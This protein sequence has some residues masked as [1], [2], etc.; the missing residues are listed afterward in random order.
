M[1]KEL[2]DLIVESRK[3]LDYFWKEVEGLARE[4][5]LFDTVADEPL[6]D[7]IQR[8]I[9]SN[10]KTY[11]Y[12]LPAQ[13]VAKLT[14]GS[15]DCRCLQVLR[16]GSGAFDARSVC[17]S[18]I[19][20]FDQQNDF[21]LGGSPEP[22]VNNP[23]RQP[24]VTPQYRHKQK[25]KRGWDDLCLV[26]ESVEDKNDPAF[27]QIVFKQTLIEI[28]KRLAGVRVVY[29]VPRRVSFRQGLRLIERFITG[30][31]GGERVQ[32]VASALFLTIG[33]RFSLYADVRRANINAADASSGQVADLEC[34]SS[35]GEI[36]LAVEVKDRDL[37]V[38]QIQD[39][40]AGMRAQ[41][42]TE[43]LFIAQQG[44]AKGDEEQA[45]ALIEKEFVSGQNIYIFDLLKLLS[46]ILALLGESGRK[47]FL[48][49]VGQELDRHRSDIAHRRA[50]A[51]LLSQ[52]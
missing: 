28:Y 50:W 15:L 5:R 29:P 30:Q 21:V 19:V 12:V 31:S 47:M 40:L 7:A 1:P 17:H 3:N 25:D 43:I 23:L 27:T 46:S 41:K 37:T 22:Y 2:N 36:V 9:N 35:D 26:L 33:Q 45:S 34:V 51:N 11:R 39:K 42:V 32:V 52:V 38:S 13:V 16:G 4:G 20:P 48:D 8:A 24:E 10:T 44:V 49:F 18:V 14:D 6:R